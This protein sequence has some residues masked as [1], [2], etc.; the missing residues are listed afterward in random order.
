MASFGNFWQ[1]QFLTISNG[2]AIPWNN[3][4]ATA[5]GV[6]LNPSNNKTI[7]VPTAGNYEI[8]F[9]V[10]ISTEGQTVPNFEQQVDLFIN[11]SPSTNS[12]FEFGIL[13]N[14]PDFTGNV[15]ECR[16]IHGQGIVKLPKN[17][18]LQLRNVSLNGET[19]KL[20][21]LVEAGAAINV[22]QLS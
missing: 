22:V 18:K 10:T 5:G 6:A 7:V 12:Q 2:Q 16:Q 11:G 19:I 17:A 21:D 13:I 9:T 8:S 1:T 20:C 15:T 14:D 3:T 4:G